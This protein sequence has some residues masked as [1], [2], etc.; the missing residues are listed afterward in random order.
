MFVTWWECNTAKRIIISPLIWQFKR[1]KRVEKREVTCSNIKLT[2]K[3]FLIIKKIIIICFL[4]AKWW[5]NFN[6]LNKVLDSNFIIL[7]TSKKDFRIK[8]RW[9]EFQDLSGLRQVLRTLTK[10]FINYTLKDKILTLIIR[11]KLTSLGYEFDP[12]QTNLKKKKKKRKKNVHV[13]CLFYF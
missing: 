13:W 7:F 11:L 1:V 2:N 12:Y 3:Y 4:L 6:S 10:I 9:V 8:F 5:D